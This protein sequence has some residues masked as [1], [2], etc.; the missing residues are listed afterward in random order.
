MDP[1]DQEPVEEI[2]VTPMQIWCDVIAILALVLLFVLPAIF[3]RYRKCALVAVRV[4]VACIAEIVYDMLLLLI[5]ATQYGSKSTEI[6]GPSPCLIQESLAASFNF[7][8]FNIVIARMALF[9]RMAQANTVGGR[10][11]DW[12]DSLIHW[13]GRIFS[14]DEFLRLEKRLQMESSGSEE[15][16][17][18]LNHENMINDNTSVHTQDSPS[19]ISKEDR[20]WL[21]KT[22]GW[23][24]F[25]TVLSIIIWVSIS[26]TVSTEELPDGINTFVVDVGGACGPVIFYL[27]GTYLLGWN[28]MQ[29]TVALYCLKLPQD[30]LGLKTEAISVQIFYTLFWSASGLVQIISPDDYS[31][32]GAYIDLSIILTHGLVTCFYPIVLYHWTEYKSSQIK[33]QG[34]DKIKTPA[35]LDRLWHTTMGRN[36]IMDIARSHFAIENV[37]LLSEL[38]HIATMPQKKYSEI[39]VKFIRRGAPYE[40]NI[41]AVL[42]RSIVATVEKNEFAKEPIQKLR[43]HIVGILFTNFRREIAEVFAHDDVH[44]V[45]S[46]STI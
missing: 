17:T 24:S 42:Q 22:V 43:D 27:I 23:L 35:D 11:K 37:L 5:V 29:L 8:V 18:A 9:V 25:W 20:I 7:V 41:P 16:I 39:Y 21:L 4:P 13:L 46:S 30:S 2:G 45:K 31:K 28:I 38:D 3:W 10:T 44:A 33:A 6:W 32:F 12:A 19:E 40:V 34:L 36:K 14:P 15:G 1:S 26:T